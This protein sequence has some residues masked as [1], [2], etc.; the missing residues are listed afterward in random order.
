MST[1]D[2]QLL[3]DAL[4]HIARTAAASRTKSR[5]TRWIQRRAEMALRGEPFD[6]KAFDLPKRDLDAPDR[7][8]MQLSHARRLLAAHGI[9]WDTN[10]AEVVAAPPS[11][12]GTVRQVV[13]LMTAAGQAPTEDQ[14]N[15]MSAAIGAI[16]PRPVPQCTEV[17]Q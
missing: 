10:P 6:V 5:R 7:L 1:D 8:K 14:E 12:S 11:W 15:A 2:A 3:R 4:D 9:A 16:W 17:P 13:D